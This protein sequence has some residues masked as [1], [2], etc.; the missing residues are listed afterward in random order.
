MKVQYEL[1]SFPGHAQLFITCRMEVTESWV[2]PGNEA[3]MSIIVFGNRLGRPFFI[4]FAKPYMSYYM[5]E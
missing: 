2:G 1:A 5:S 4:K 3:S